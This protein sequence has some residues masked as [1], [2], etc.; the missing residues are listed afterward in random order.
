MTQNLKN[1]EVI[2]VDDGYNDKS[3][4]QIKMKESSRFKKY[5]G[6]VT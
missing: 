4:I 2:V 3:P 1:I 5:N 6:I